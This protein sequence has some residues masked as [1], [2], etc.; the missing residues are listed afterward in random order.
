MNASSTLQT[1]R[2]CE[3]DTGGTV[4]YF[5]RACQGRWPKTLQVDVVQELWMVGGFDGKEWLATVDAFDP[6][7]CSWHERPPTL[8]N[9]GLWL[10]LPAWYACVRPFIII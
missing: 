5:P 3:L 1:L 7:T 8:V 6:A 2:I 4:G 10:S 9:R